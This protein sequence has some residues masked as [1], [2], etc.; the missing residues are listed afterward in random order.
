MN[1]GRAGPFHR[2]VPVL[3]ARRSAESALVLAAT[4]L[5]EAGA[6]V[7]EAAVTEATHRDAQGLAIHTLDVCHPAIAATE[8]SVVLPLRPSRLCATRAARG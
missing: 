2:D 8:P 5:T 3:V 4:D 6:A 7:L 1:H